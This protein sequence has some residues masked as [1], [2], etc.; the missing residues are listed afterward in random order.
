M[1][2]L[3]PN[4]TVASSYHLPEDFSLTWEFVKTKKLQ[5]G[6]GA[7]ISYVPT[8]TFGGNDLEKTHLKDYNKNK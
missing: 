1:Y 6:D 7:H 4:L 3:I 2:C 8:T 5:V